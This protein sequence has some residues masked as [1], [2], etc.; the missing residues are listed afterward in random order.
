MFCISFC[1]H[2]RFQRILLAR[3]FPLPAMTVLYDLEVLEFRLHTEIRNAQS[4]ATSL[5]TSNG[6]CSTVPMRRR[7]RFTNFRGHQWMME[8]SSSLCDF[9]HRR[10]DVSKE[11]SVVWIGGAV[12]NQKILNHLWHD[13][14]NKNDI[15]H[16]NAWVLLSQWHFTV[17]ELQTQSLFPSLG[18]AFG[19]ARGT[20]GK[21][22]LARSH[23]V[24]RRRLAR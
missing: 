6:P 4:L 14:T 12:T 10:L 8:W 5:G 2:L 1:R 17:L 18:L 11:T 16:I 9:Q 23:C 21:V 15:M 13:G 20:K 19:S 24:L 3:G 7:A 22:G